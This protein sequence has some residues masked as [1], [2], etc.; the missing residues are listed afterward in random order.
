M[1]QL[2]AAEQLEKQAGDLRNNGQG[3]A[4]V[5][6]YKQAADL[7]L[8][9][10][11]EQRSAECWHMVGVSYKVENDIDAA[12]ETL[13]KAAQLHRE[14]GNKV[15]VG[16]VYRD[17][18]IAYAYRKEHDKAIGWLEKSE[19]ALRN[20]GADAELGMTESKIGLHY[21]EVKDYDKAEQ[22]LD[23]GLASIRKESNWFYEMTAL[24]HLAALHLVRE[25]YSEAIT[26]LWS[27][28]G[29]I[30][31]A[32]EQDGQKRRLAQIYGLLAHGYL[33][34]GNTKSGVQ[35]FEQAVGLLKPMAGN[36]SEVVYEDIRARG[37][38]ER[39]KTVSRAD[40]D[41]LAA[42]IGLTALPHVRQWRHDQG[43]TNT[44]KRL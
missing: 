10:G 11:D 15:G 7:F 41:Q 3:L 40:Y 5:E 25:R 21:L 8:E 17:I 31:Q 14:A 30:Y 33:G 16:R 13:E 39:L 9:A 44:H 32:N 19:E 22:W 35:F 34:V 26:T 36:V 18:G 28:V 12:I 6:K 2:H 37:F 38:A 42:K 43:E 20:S 1:N 24:L 29:L 27:C 23:R 4:A